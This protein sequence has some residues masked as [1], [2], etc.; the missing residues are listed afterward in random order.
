MSLTL[1]RPAKCRFRAPRRARRRQRPEPRIPIT[2]SLPPRTRLPLIPRAD[3]VSRNPGGETM[4][5]RRDL[6]GFTAAAAAVAGLEVR[7]ARAA[8]DV[9][10]FERGEAELQPEAAFYNADRIDAVLS[11]IDKA[12]IADPVPDFPAKLLATAL[13]Y[14]GYSRKANEPAITEMLQ[15]FY[16]PFREGGNLVPFCAAGVG[17]C[18]AQVYAG[19]ATGVESYRSVLRAVDYHNFWPSS[20]CRSM[21]LVAM[22]KARFRPAKPGVTVPQKGWVVLYDWTGSGGWDS[23]DH[24]GIVID[25]DGAQLHTIEFNT[26]DPSNPDQRDGGVVMRKTRPYNRTVKGFVVTDTR[27]T[28]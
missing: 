27:R 2:S 17:Y 12:Q 18:A 7:G 1:V 10:G 28:S 3:S 21:A 26:G 11:G 8:D 16:A 9:L 14:E 13:R 23:T 24:C 22:G 19:G 4:L 25:A 20:A 6:I 5:G 15:V